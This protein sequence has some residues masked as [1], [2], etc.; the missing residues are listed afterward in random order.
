MSS[1]AGWRKLVPGTYDVG[2]RHPDTLEICDPNFRQALASSIDADWLFY[3]GQVGG[4]KT[5]WLAREAVDYCVTYPRVQ[6]ALFRRTLKDLERSIVLELRTMIPPGLAIFNGQLMRWEFFNGALLWLCYCATEADVYQYQ[7]AQWG[8]LGIDESTHFTEFQFRYLVTRV[9]SP[10]SGVPRKVRLA[11]NPGSV[12]HGW[13]KRLFVRPVDFEG[14]DAPRPEQVWRPRR[15]AWW[16]MD[17]PVPTRAFVPASFDDNYILKATNPEYLA[18]VY[19]L[20]GDKGRQLAEGDWDANDSMIVGGTWQEWKRVT[21]EDELLLAQGLTPGQVIPWHII[22]NPTWEPGPGDL[23]FGSVDYGYGAPW[24]FHLTAAMP[25]GHTRT[26][27][28]LYLTRKRDEQQAAMI[29]R[30]LEGHHWQ[31]EWMVMDP[32]MWNSRKESGLAKS[33]AEVYMDIL[34]N[35]IIKPGA[36]GRPARMSRPNRWLTALSTAPDGFP[37]WTVTTACPNLI[38]TVPDVPW[39]DDDPEVEDDASENHCYEDMG[40]FFEARPHQPATK[41]P[42]AYPDLDPL[43]RQHALWRRQ[44]EEPARAGA[45]LNLKRAFK[46]L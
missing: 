24:S 8:F 17:L 42:E 12:G 38:R 19:Q 23:V 35:I 37:W 2:Y 44:H 25:G 7:S 26:F 32:A 20:G 34:P 11:G 43:S 45:R 14:P 16:K 4:G 30:V 1:R 22:P 40:R 18:N 27:F 13:H 29:K 36:A 33:I 46:N 10:R 9:R 28:E 31:P 41:E 21:L 15:P 39:D 5:A 6:A 3:G